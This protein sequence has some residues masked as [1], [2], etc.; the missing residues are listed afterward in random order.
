MVLAIAGMVLA[1]VF[2]IGI[3]AGDA[4]FSL[5]R[6]ALEASDSDIS[7]SD[8]RVTIQ[9]IALRPA[10]TFVPG[11]PVTTGDVLRLETEVVMAR[12]TQC[13]LK[14]WA[15]ILRLEIRDQDGGGSAVV[16][17]AADRE[18]VL[19]RLPRGRA[20][21]SYSTDGSTWTSSFDNTPTDQQDFGN[22]RSSNLWVRLRGG[23]DLDLIARATTGRPDIWARSDES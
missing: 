1:I 16:C 18:A 2:S 15:G 17:R 8:Y 10:N 6:R 3:R 20:Q 13:A 14:G 11:D 23:P 9:S 19:F 5:G 12:S 7:R 21:F 4:G 22:I